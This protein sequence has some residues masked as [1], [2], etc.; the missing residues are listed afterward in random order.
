VGTGGGFPDEDPQF[1]E[2]SGPASYGYTADGPVQ[3]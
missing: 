1:T 3:Y 2:V